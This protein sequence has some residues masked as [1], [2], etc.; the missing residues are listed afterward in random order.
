MV[1]LLMRSCV[2][3]SP[4]RNQIET[5]SG[6]TK[7]P[8]GIWAHVT[9]HSQNDILSYPICATCL[10]SLSTRRPHTFSPGPQLEGTSGKYRQALKVQCSCSSW[11]WLWHTGPPPRGSSID[12]QPKDSPGH[13]SLGQLC[14]YMPR[15][16]LT[17]KHGQ[18]PQNEGLLRPPL[19]DQNAHAASLR[20]RI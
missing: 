20:C 16:I 18:T 13:G 19:P 9:A 1:A 8:N 4:K 14:T 12:M 3:P 5:K 6:P 17:H 10:P 2:M 15:G 11:H 7:K